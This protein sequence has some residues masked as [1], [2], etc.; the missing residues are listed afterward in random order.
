VKG[1]IFPVFTLTFYLIIGEIMGIERV[2]AAIR[3]IPDFPKPG[4]IFKDITPILHSGDIFAEVIDL[5][6][7]PYLD[8]PPD[9]IV[10]VESRG[11]IFG[12]AMAYKLGCGIVPVRKKGKLPYDTYE[13]SYELEYGTATVEIHTDALKEEDKI[14]IIDDLLAPG[15]TAGA[16]VKLIEQL[17]ANIIGIDFLIE[18]AFLNGRENLDQYPINS[19]IVVD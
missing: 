17:G 15:G 18:L 9:Y 8:N 7:V 6:C 1:I 3:D 11:F 19:L 16:A 5:L 14:V 13:A 2:E 10:A 12:S 4:I